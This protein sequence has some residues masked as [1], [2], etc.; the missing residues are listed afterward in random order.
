MM[1]NNKKILL[2]LVV[3]ICFIVTSF[4]FAD[5]LAL[6]ETNAEGTS[7]FDI[8]S[9]VIKL[10]NTTISN[11]TTE[12]IVVDN[13]NYESSENVTNGFIAPGSTAYF[14]LVLDVTE[15]DVAV[16]YNITLDLESLGYAN[17]ISFTMEE[18][19]ENSVVKT[20]ANTYS[21]I[22]SLSQIQNNQTVTLRINVTWE[23]ILEFDESDTELGMNRGSTLAIPINVKA[24]QYLGETLVPYVEPEIDGENDLT[25]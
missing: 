15:C 21:G 19:G 9:W 2:W 7:N 13:F 18:I 22:I 11:G 14:D 24:V 4:V 17:N 8:A 20:D 5:T 6:F 23:D 3:I 12:T 16:L 1:R 25:E 10:S